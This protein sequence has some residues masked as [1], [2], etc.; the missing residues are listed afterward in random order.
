MGVLRPEPPSSA[1]R[2]LPQRPPSD[3]CAGIRKPNLA[4]GAALARRK[5]SALRLCRPPLRSALSISKGGETTPLRLA[6]A[7]AKRSSAYRYGP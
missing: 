4:E 6:T 3:S 7:F 5:A 1:G 2:S